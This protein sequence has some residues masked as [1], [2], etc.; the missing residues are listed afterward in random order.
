MAFSD[1]QFRGGVIA[2]AVILVAAIAG[3]RFFGSVSLP[4][5]PRPSTPTGTSTE[6]LTKGA[7]TTNIYLE[8]LS[9]DAANAGT[10]APTI[11]EMSIEFPYT[12]DQARHVIEVG[13]AATQVGVLAM[14]AERSGDLLVL[15]IKNV[16]KD[17][18][19]YHIATEIVP[20]AS[21]TN[22]RPLPINANVIAPEETIVRT[23]CMFREGTAVVA[24]RI[25]T[26]RLSSLSAYLL[27]QVPPATLGVAPVIARQHRFPRERCA[28]NLSRN[29][30]SQMEKGEITWRDL[31]DFYARHRCQT[32]QFPAEYRAVTKDA[33]R[34][35]PAVSNGN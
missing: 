5:K 25:E 11:D 28:T 9:K 23:E 29:V 22:A 34:A 16:S 24:T 20:A 10:Q 8:L 7:A 33:P 13:Q 15:E 12:L 21:C 31:A 1:A 17:T 6:L 2:G 3:I 14:R 32:Y 18:L 4:D 35:I 30:Q 26:M 27:D 19:A